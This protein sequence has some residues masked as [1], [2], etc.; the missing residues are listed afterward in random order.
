MDWPTRSMQGKGCQRLVGRA[1]WMKARGWH[2]FP[3][4][5]TGAA[6]LKYMVYILTHPHWKSFEHLSYPESY[7]H[8]ESSSRPSR[9][10]EICTFSAMCMASAMHSRSTSARWF[11]RSSSCDSLDAF[12]WGMGWREKTNIYIYIIYIY[13]DTYIY[14]YIYIDTYI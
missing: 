12:C 10:S 8:G 5:A 4:S 13:I 1:W 2:R 3:G 11:S 9:T 14:R 7:P 6:A